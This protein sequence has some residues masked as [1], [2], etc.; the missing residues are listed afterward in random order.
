MQKKKKFKRHLIKIEQ[1]L[2]YWSLIYV[3]IIP[4]CLLCIN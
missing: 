2:L 4:N 3:E 1:Y